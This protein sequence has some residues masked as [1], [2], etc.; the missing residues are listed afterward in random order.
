MSVRNFDALFLV[1]MLTKPLWCSLGILH[2]PIP[3]P[4]PPPLLNSPFPYPNLD[5]VDRCL[6]CCH[7]PCLHH[8]CLILLAPPPST[9]AGRLLH[10]SPLIHSGLLS[11]FPHWLVL[12]DISWHDD[13]HQG[14]W[15]IWNR[16]LPHNVS[17]SWGKAF[18]PCGFRVLRTQRAFSVCLVPSWG[19]IVWYLSR[20]TKI[21]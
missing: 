14:S 5:L 7:R 15:M 2:I 13:L 11:T 16:M 18:P 17:R 12:S 4:P 21:K 20:Q 10:L 3:S 6:H 19:D 1:S 8:S 9:L